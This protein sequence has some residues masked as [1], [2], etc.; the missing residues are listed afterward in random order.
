MAL[1]NCPDCNKEIS[2]KAP[3]CP[4]CGAP[5][6]NDREAKGSGVQHLTTTQSTSKKLK[7][8]MLISGLLLFVGMAWTIVSYEPAIGADSAA[9][10][11]SAVS[12]IWFIS[13]RIRVWWHHK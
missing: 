10:V 3:T 8:E 11:I 9:L 12:L 4:G 5:I 7:M 1:I 13:A 6:A 2:D